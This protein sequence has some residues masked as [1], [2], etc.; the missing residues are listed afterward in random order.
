MDD[1]RQKAPDLESS[2]QHTWVTIAMIVTTI[3]SVIEIGS[4]LLF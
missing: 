2:F 3:E 1:F 4:R